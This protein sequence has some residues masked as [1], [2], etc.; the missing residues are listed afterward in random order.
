MS[1]YSNVYVPTTNVRVCAFTC[2]REEDLPKGQK[3]LA[4]SRCNETCYVSRE[5]QKL[6]WPVH[7][8]VC[9][10]V[11]NDQEEIRNKDLVFK[12]GLAELKAC[13]GA[14]CL[15]LTDPLKHVKG[16]YLLY[17]F[18]QLRRFF[19]DRKMYL[20]LPASEKQ[21][22]YYGCGKAMED[23][24]MPF[25]SSSKAFYTIFAIPGFMNYFFS[26]DLFLSSAMKEKKLLGLALP[27]EEKIKPSDQLPVEYCAIL[28]KFIASV[29]F[30]VS[31]D[32]SGQQNALLAGCI[33][34]MMR[35]WSDKYARSS[36]PLIR[37]LDDP[38]QRTHFISG[39]FLVG[40]EDK[41][42]RNTVILKAMKK[43]E[44]IPGLTGKDLLTNLVEDQNFLEFSLSPSRNGDHDARETL[45]CICNSLFNLDEKT[46][47]PLP[48]AASLSA[49]D[50]LRLLD[51]CHHFKNP[52]K[53]LVAP[54][55]DMFG[56]TKTFLYNMILSRH[57]GTFLDM[58][59][60]SKDL[61][62]PLEEKTLALLDRCYK[63]L[64]FRVFP[65]YK[66]WISIVEPRYQRKMKQE[67]SKVQQFPNEIA[68]MIL[69]FAMQTEWE[70]IFDPLFFRKL[71]K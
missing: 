46:R 7:K 14:I 19:E 40:Y 70:D 67:N 68:V 8:K 2:T 26:E 51:K 33:Q 57:G 61:D 3:L 11:D 47:A 10:S 9:C 58:Y 34:R 6:H 55:K 37:D 25:R 41:I 17:C 52:R 29:G 30:A 71:G 54:F 63:M 50:R 64:T 43:G 15:I 27:P 44:V 16:R 45:V 62:S 13:L 53:P 4:C 60:K 59:H 65:S 66:V 42:R 5:V 38:C 39:L 36:F 18:Q 22:L 12:D 35:L 31:T 23:L 20:R 48:A 32:S 28:C 24:C 49:E 1:N 21:K 69:E 56:D